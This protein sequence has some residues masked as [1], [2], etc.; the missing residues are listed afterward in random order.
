MEDDMKQKVD[1]KDT[2]KCEPCNR[3]FSQQYDLTIHNSIFN[4]ANITNN[5][6]VINETKKVEDEDRPSNSEVF[7]QNTISEDDQPSTSTFQ[8][9]NAGN[10]GDLQSSD[11]E[12]QDIAVHAGTDT[13]SKFC[14]MCQKQFLSPS[15]L[16]THI[17][18]HTGEKPYSCTYCTKVF[19]RKQQL[20][21][22]LRTHTGEKPYS[23]TH[24]TKNFVDRTTLCRVHT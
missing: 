21:N 10:F 22:H 6:T 18:T 15:H 14:T 12:V 19:A 11:T 3:S 2:F 17:R 4:N 24:C 1:G 9:H 13:K 23:C 7:Q 16:K 5:H 20:Q 8:L